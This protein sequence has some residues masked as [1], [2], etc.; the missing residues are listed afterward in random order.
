METGAFFCQS[1]QFHCV[2]NRIFASK[3]N[4][5]KTYSKLLLAIIFFWTTQMYSQKSGIAELGLKGKPAL[6]KESTFEIEPTDSLFQH[7]QLLFY[8]INVFDLEGNKTEDRKYDA[9][10]KLLHTYLYAFNPQGL[11]S[12]M[13]MIGPDGT[14]IRWIDYMYNQEG[15]LVEDQSFAADSTPEKRFTYQYDQMGLLIEDISFLGGQMSMRFTYRYD[16]NGNKIE[17]LRFDPEGILR[18]RITYS[19]DDE[20]R[21]IEELTF[22]GADQLIDKRSYSYIN[23]NQNNWIRKYVRHNQLTDL[24]VEREIQYH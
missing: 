18:K 24:L 9:Q 15:L 21:L 20:G 17:N 13:N 3:R 8:Y 14:L 12:K 5:M 7:K 22:K 19:Y 2:D 6:L 1:G 16:L 23:D 11:R 10:G 4:K